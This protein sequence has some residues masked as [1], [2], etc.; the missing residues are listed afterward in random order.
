MS[1]SNIDCVW[2]LSRRWW[3]IMCCQTHNK[4]TGTPGSAKISCMASFSFFFF[5]S[6]LLLL[7]FCLSVLAMLLIY[8]G[9]KNLTLHS[10]GFLFWNNQLRIFTMQMMV[11][12][13]I[14]HFQWRIW[15]YTLYIYLLVNIYVYICNK[16]NIYS[17]LTM[18]EAL[19]W[20]L[21]KYQ[22]I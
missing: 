19:I 13:G 16:M 6:S 5:P 4:Q 2:Y 15:I 21:N 14:I 18:C 10:P 8:L 1:F 20:S 7:F 17:L 3:C 22:L 9:S 12:W 11:V